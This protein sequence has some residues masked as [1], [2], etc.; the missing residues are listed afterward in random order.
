MEKFYNGDFKWHFCG[1]L[2]GGE[3]HGDFEKSHVLQL[4]Y[5]FSRQGNSTE[6]LCFP[7]VSMQSGKDG[8]SFSFMWRVFH[9]E[10]K[11]GKTGGHFLFIP[12]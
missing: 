2:A 7:F 11:N 5:R 6:T 8:N 10:K 1:I 12:F 3:K 4:L 9:V